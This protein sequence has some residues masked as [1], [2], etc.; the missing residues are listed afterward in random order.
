VT[1]YSTPVVAA[2]YESS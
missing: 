2:E 1:F